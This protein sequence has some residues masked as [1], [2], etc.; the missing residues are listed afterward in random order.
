IVVTAT[1]LSFSLPFTPWQLGL[2]AAT[3]VVVAPLVLFVDWLVLQFHVKPVRQAALARPGGNGPA[4]RDR[5]AIVR[6]LN[7][8]ILTV[9]RVMVLHGPFI[10]AVLT[11]TALGVLNPFLGGGFELWQ[12]ALMWCTLFVTV[13][14]H[15]VLEFFAVQ[16]AVRHRVAVLQGPGEELRPEE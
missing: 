9:F 6:A 1:L 2:V 15:A 7:L 10:L 14:A 16:S 8:P 4:P 12:L 5:E 11:V 13:P 3:G